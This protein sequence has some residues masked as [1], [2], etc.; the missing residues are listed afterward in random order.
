MIRHEARDDTQRSTFSCLPASESKKFPHF[1]TGTRSAMLDQLASERIERADGRSPSFACVFSPH[2]YW[3][4][5]RCPLRNNEPVAFSVMEEPCFSV[6]SFHSQHG[7][8]GCEVGWHPSSFRIGKTFRDLRASANFRRRN[9][10]G[11]LLPQVNS[12][13]GRKFAEQL[14]HL[15]NWPY[16]M[17]ILGGK[18]S[19]GNQI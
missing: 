13:G 2:R 5:M 14:G 6:L 12:A 10:S 7:D 8:R 19:L 9:E 11:V 17:G 18:G 3:L 15:C 1:F 4:S 16:Q